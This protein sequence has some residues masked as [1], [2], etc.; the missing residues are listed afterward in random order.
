MTTTEQTTWQQDIAE[1]A[2]EA[3]TDHG[4]V[5]VRL[6][7]NGPAVISRLYPHA[8]Y[9]PGRMLSVVWSQATRMQ[10][11]DFNCTYYVVTRDAESLRVWVSVRCILCTVDARTPTMD[12]WHDDEGVWRQI[13]GD[14]L[15]PFATEAEAEA[16][17]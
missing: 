13:G 14:V 8:D 16:I 17:R 7:S 3:L 2:R 1:V 6:G 10:N 15:G 5:I 9:Q 4:A 12:I 11:E